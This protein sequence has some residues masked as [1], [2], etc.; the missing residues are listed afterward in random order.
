VE[1]GAAEFDQRSPA[2]LKSYLKNMEMRQEVWVTT[3]AFATPTC[4]IT[5]H[6]WFNVYVPRLTHGARSARSGEPDSSRSPH[7]DD[8]AIT[9]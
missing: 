8:S 9:E 4:K 6:L 5:V 1:L 7:R 2:G 3:G